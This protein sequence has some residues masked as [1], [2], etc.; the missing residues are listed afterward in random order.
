M[1]RGL[2]L[3]YKISKGSSMIIAILVNI[4]I[5]IGCLCGL[6][7]HSIAKMALNK[8]DTSARVKES[9]KY[10]LEVY[11]RHQ[12]KYALFSCLLWPLILKWMLFG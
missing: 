3:F 5:I 6:L 4:Y 9:A 11:D 1:L 12:V 7:L 10:I 2:I 8:V